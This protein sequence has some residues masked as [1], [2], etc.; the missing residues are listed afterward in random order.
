MN[1]SFR[2]NFQGFLHSNRF[3]NQDSDKRIKILTA[4]KFPMA[5]LSFALLMH[6]EYS[7]LPFSV[8]FLIGPSMLPTV[9]PKGDV[10]L[11]VKSWAMDH[12][13]VGHVIVFQDFKGGYACKRIIGVE[14]N[15][16]NVYGEYASTIYKDRKDLG[17]PAIPVPNM[18][19]PW[20]NETQITNGRIKVPTNTLWVEGD[21]PLDS[22]DSRHYGPIPVSN[23]KGRILYRLWPRKRL[24]EKSSTCFVGSTRPDPTKINTSSMTTPQVR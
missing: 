12:P 13:E 6:E 23:V 15:D 11:R 20:Q 9:Q 14:N 21:N 3:Q 8:D 18:L 5:I 22:V 19:P 16:V 2:R 7:P 24:G 1:R 4:V 10:Y 17:V